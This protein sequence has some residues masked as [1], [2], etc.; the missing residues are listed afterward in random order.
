MLPE[1]QIQARL[2]WLIGT[3]GRLHSTSNLNTA[4]QG[5]YL[6]REDYMRFV[7]EAEQ[8]YQGQTTA[9]LWSK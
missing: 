7:H 9:V 2:V 1:T 8:W 6:S 3:D 4:H 5:G